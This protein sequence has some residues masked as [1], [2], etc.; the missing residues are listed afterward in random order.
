M[1]LTSSFGTAIKPPLYKWGFLSLL[2]FVIGQQIYW[3]QEQKYFHLA[4]LFAFMAFND[5]RGHEL[6]D[7]RIDVLFA[8]IIFLTSAT[9]IVEAVSEVDL[10]LLYALLLSAGGFV[11]IK[12]LLDLR[13]IVARGLKDYIADNHRQ[14]F[15]KPTKFLQ[16][17]LFG[18]SGIIVVAVAYA[19]SHVFIFGLFN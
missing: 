10:S 5:M 12:S 14:I 4:L 3:P 6:R 7:L 18:V 19:V 17:L 8:G 9:S 11:A 15:N 2:V 13:V 16:F 1:T